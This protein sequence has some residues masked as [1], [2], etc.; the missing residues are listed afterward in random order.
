MAGAHA[1]PDHSGTPVPRRTPDAIRV[2]FWNRLHSTGPQSTLDH[3]NTVP[4]WDVVLL[5]E[6]T[7][8]FVDAARKSYGD[9]RVRSALDHIDLSQPKPNGAAVVVS[10]SVEILEE[11]L[12]FP[13]ASDQEAPRPERSL[14]VRCRVR[15]YELT[16]LATHVM[17]TYDGYERKMRT[18]AGLTDLGADA[19]GPLVIGLDGNNWYD[20]IGDGIEP[21]IAP[22]PYNHAETAIFHG[23]QPPHRLRDTLRVAIDRDPERRQQA[24]EHL[25][26]WGV[27]V[28]THRR[29]NALDRMDRIYATPDIAV[30]AAG[31]DADAFDSSDHALVWADLLPGGR[32]PLEPIQSII[33]PTIKPKPRRAGAGVRSKATTVEAALDRIILDDQYGWNRRGYFARVALAS[34]AGDGATRDFIEAH[35]RWA[36]RPSSVWSPTRNAINRSWRSVGGP[37]LRPDVDEL[38]R[39]DGRTRVHSMHRG[40]AAEAVEHLRLGDLVASLDDPDLEERLRVRFE[41]AEG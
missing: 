27:L 25:D 29:V 16:V 15:G 40:L 28:A 33:D 4:D 32:D 34:A 18:Y 3:L 37:E 8:P 12:T 26:R 6:C 20:W 35:Y 5:V 13:E 14:T 2:V 9:G 17:N 19:T 21:P 1:Q 30:L 22:G 24:L 10:D 41:P 39:Y 31:V 7:Q 23:R 36:D 38:V 11:H